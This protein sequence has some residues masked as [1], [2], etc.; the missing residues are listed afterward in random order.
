M[1][2]WVAGGYGLPPDLWV[3]GWV[4]VVR[5]TRV[6]GAPN[7]GRCPDYANAERIAQIVRQHYL[8]REDVEALPPPGPPTEASL[9]TG[10]L[11]A[12]AWDGGHADS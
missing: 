5:D 3:T 1:C 7:T 11:R 2:I 8:A 4:T 9:L 12:V 6:F 10:Q